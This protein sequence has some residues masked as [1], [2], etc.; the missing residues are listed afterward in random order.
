MEDVCESGFNVID[1]PP[2]ALED[3]KK[4]FIRLAKFHA[5]TFY[6]VNENVRSFTK[7][8]KAFRDKIFLFKC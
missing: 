4:I 5:G 2:E 7:F 6:L 1:R 3:S 8:F